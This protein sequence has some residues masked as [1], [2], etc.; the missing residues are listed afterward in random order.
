MYVLQTGV[1]TAKPY[2]HPILCDI[3]HQ[4]LFVGKKSFAK[5]YANLFGIDMDDGTF[6]HTIPMAVIAFAATAVSYSVDI[7]ISTL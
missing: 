3:L 6:V 1:N 5:T 4:V 7:V 2:Q